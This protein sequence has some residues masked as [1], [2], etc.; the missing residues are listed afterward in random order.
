LLPRPGQFAVGDEIA[1]HANSVDIAVEQL[2]GCNRRAAVEYDALA[3]R[4]HCGALKQALFL[5]AA[6]CRRALIAL[7]GGVEAGRSAV[8]RFDGWSNPMDWPL[9]RPGEAQDQRLFQR[10]EICEGYLLAAFRDVLDLTP[11]AVDREG[12]LYHFENALSQYMQLIRLCPFREPPAAAASRAEVS[13]TS[14]PAGM[15]AHAH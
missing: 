7:E 6:E 5:R 15:L 9:E 10:Y 11:A 8:V 13:Q 3:R 2:L 4:M 14:F 12:L 1:M